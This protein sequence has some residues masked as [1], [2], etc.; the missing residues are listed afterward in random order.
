MKIIYLLLLVVPF[1]AQAQEI[2]GN[3]IID[4][5]EAC[6]DGNTYSGD[7]CRFDCLAKEICGGGFVDFGEECDDHNNT[8]NDGCSESCTFER[9]PLDDMPQRDRQVNNPTTNTT[10]IPVATSTTNPSTNIFHFLRETQKSNP[11][12]FSAV[13]PGRF[14]LVLGGGVRLAGIVPLPELH[15]SLGLT[16][17]LSLQMSGAT[18][19]FFG[20]FN[21]GLRLRLFYRDGVSVGLRADISAI[22]ASPDFTNGYGGGFLISL[23][24]EF[25]QLSLGFGARTNYTDTGEPPSPVKLIYGA[26]S[27]EAM[28]RKHWGI[29]AQFILSEDSFG[30]VYSLAVGVLFRPSL[31]GTD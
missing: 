13:G 15:L 27:Y 26:T 12:L 8:A 20:A 24:R 28:L 30:S 18:F 6:D 3:G 19:G 25:S 7:G 11:F 31:F 14:K 21:G 5:N 22:G 17:F 9:L 2:C 16:H 29:Y 10:S 4:P 23:G 1:V